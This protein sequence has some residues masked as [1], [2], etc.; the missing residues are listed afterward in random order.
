MSRQD[1]LIELYRQMHRDSPTHFPGRSVLRYAVE[2][3]T[4]IRKHGAKTLLDYGCGQGSQYDVDGVSRWWGIEPYRYDPAVDRY[5]VKPVGEFDGVICTDVLEHIPQENLSETLDEIFGFAR[6]FAFFTI[7][8]RP[9]KRLLPNGE[10]TH[11]N[12]QPPEWWTHV[13]RMRRDRHK[14]DVRVEFTD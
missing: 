6:S 2:V 5:S 13:M 10:N 14:L 11:C 8:C 4:L 3:N 12:I 9:A 7:C 1:D